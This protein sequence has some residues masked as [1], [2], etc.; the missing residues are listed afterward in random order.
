M[1][2]AIEAPFTL[3]QKPVEIVLFNAVKFAHLPFGLVPE[4][5]DAVDVRVVVSQIP[6]ND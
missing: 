3:L 1:V 4:I 2:A 6:A 5:L